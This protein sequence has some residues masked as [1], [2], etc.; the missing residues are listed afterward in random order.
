[1]VSCIGGVS[2]VN[3]LYNSINFRGG[4]GAGGDGTATI[5][6]IASGT[7]ASIQ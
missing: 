6:T 4:G 1:M 3:T 7:S 2:A 5:G